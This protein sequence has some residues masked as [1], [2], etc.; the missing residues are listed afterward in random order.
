MCAIVGSFNKFKLYELYKLNNYRGEL[1]YSFTR[2][3]PNE[4]EIEF[5]TKD[6]GKMPDDLI[7]TQGICSKF[8]LT[9]S[10]AP[11]TDASTDNVHPSNINDTLLWHN[12]IIKQR[13]ISHQIWDTQWLHEQ[14]L[15]KG[16][17][18]LSEI[19]GTFACVMYK[20]NNLYA[21]RNEISP[22]FYDDDF[23]FSS[24]QFD[25]SMPLPAN[26]VFRLDLKDKKLVGVA[27]FKTY[28]NPYFFID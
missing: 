26:L 21:F 7:E 28:E 24:T 6:S 15:E 11:T 13:V 17:D 22:L 3:N 8:M 9:H 23:N 27:K 2:F 20:N 12:G 1:S 4:L 16:W 10:Q 5:M 18:V 25:N 14:I 19:D